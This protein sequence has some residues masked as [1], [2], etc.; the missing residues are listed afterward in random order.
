MGTRAVWL[1]VGATFA[2]SGHAYDVI[3]HSGISDHGVRQSVLN[4]PAS[5]IV[6]T[7]CGAQGADDKRCLL[8]SSGSYLNTL[9]P[10]R[11]IAEGAVRE[12]DGDRALNHFF[13]P[14]EEGKALRYPFGFTLGDPSPD[15][16]LEDRFEIGD[17]A[18]SLSDARG[19]LHDALTGASAAERERA[20]GATFEALGHVVH[21]LQDMAQPQH[22]RNDVHCDR[23]RSTWFNPLPIPSVCFVTGAFRPSAYEGFTRAR[24]L[25]LPLSGYES[26]DFG[27]F[28]LPRELWSDSGMGIAEFTSNNFVSTGSNFYMESGFVVA[29]ARHPNPAGT[30][31]FMVKRRITD[32]DLLGPQ[33]TNQP[34]SGEIWFVGTPVVDRYHESEVLNQRSSSFSIFDAELEEA[35]QRLVFTLNRFNYAAAN[36]FLLPRAAAYSTGLINY[37]F[38]GRIGIALPEDGVYGI[39]DHGTINAAGQGFDK[40]KLKLSN[41]SPDGVKPSGEKVPQAMQGGTLVAV[42]KYTLNSCY[43]PD[44]T[45][46]FAVRIDTGEIVN[47]A[48]CSFA[49]YFAGEEQI[50][51]SSAQ[52]AVSLDKTPVE[53]TFDFSSQPIPVNARDLRI[54]VVYT[55]QLGAEADGIAFGGRDISEPTHLMVYNNSDY[56]AVDGKFYTPQQIRADAALSERVKGQDIDPKPL[57]TVMLNFVPLR[58]ITGEAGPV[59]VNGYVRVAV[60]ADID[61]PFTLNVLTRFEGGAFAESSFGGIWANTT[62]LRAEQPYITPFGIYRGPRG[63]FVDVVFMGNSS[64]PLLDGELVTMSGRMTTDPG[65]TPIP[66]QF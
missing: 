21:H 3:T 23:F 52:L 13:D 61:R 56:Y 63:H 18:S 27:T 38:R 36:E 51:Q 39:I 1:L 20:L 45:G 32:A 57:K 58:N 43:L 50:A 40:L 49:Q 10:L 47:P 14:Q 9:T 19:L 2:S 25:G 33:G 48:N 8:P 41:A 44:L 34:L 53:F 16:T 55:G 35:G 37:F 42:A 65:P 29:E 7:L 5:G 28:E 46:D 24:G 15:W 11:L 64:A 54:Q 30:G 22:V 17:Q 31:A 6:E 4:D 60:L 59:P 26:A 12:D 66:L 62:D